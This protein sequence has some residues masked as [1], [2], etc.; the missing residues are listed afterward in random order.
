MFEAEFN[1]LMVGEDCFDPA[2]RKNAI[3]WAWARIHTSPQETQ[4]VLEMLWDVA[5]ETGCQV[6]F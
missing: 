2:R 4:E 1:D 5:H 3:A 6:N